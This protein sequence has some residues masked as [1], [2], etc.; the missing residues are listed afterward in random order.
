M[1]RAN[2]LNHGRA[3]RASKDAGP[4]QHLHYNYGQQQ[5]VGE[6]RRKKATFSDGDVRLNIAVV[7]IARD[8]E[9][10]WHCLK[11]RGRL[12]EAPRV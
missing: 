9:S 3:I 1:S 4:Q 6:V 10:P 11:A 12:K 8:A 7:A 5:S 2:A